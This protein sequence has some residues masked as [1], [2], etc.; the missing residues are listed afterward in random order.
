MPSDG[1][2]GR[3]Q[4]TQVLFTFLSANAIIGS[5]RP[6]A[7]IATA[8]TTAPLAARFG[9][10]SAIAREAIDALGAAWARRAR[11]RAG[12]AA[13]G[14]WAALFDG[15][16]SGV[17]RHA[18]LAQSYL[19]L[20]LA[21]VESVLRG[22]RADE[23]DP[24]LGSIGLDVPAAG[25]G[26]PIR[27]RIAAAAIDAVDEARAAGDRGADLVGELYAAVLAASFRR[28]LGEF[29]TPRWVVDLVLDEVG[30]RGAAALTRSVLDPC[31]G[32]GAFL[33]PAI[34][35]VRRRAEAARL[36]RAETL[37]RVVAHVR[38]GDVHPLA[39]LA[40]RVSYRLAI[41]DLVGAREAPP[42]VPIEAACAL[43]PGEG[44]DEVDLVVGNPP[45][46]R[47]GELPGRSRD[48]AAAAARRLGIVPRGRWGGTELDVSGV[49]ALAATERHLRDGGTLS[50]VVTAT[51]LRAPASAGLRRLR[52]PDGTPLRLRRVH[53]LTAA[54]PFPEV[55]AD[56]AVVTWERGRETRWPI[57]WERW[58]AAR[59]G[60]RRRSRRCAHPLPPDDRLCVLPPDRGELVA[61]LAG[62]S[63]AWRGRKGI[64]TDCNGVYFPRLLGPGETSGLTS[65]ETRPDAGRRPVPSFRASVETE[66]LFP[67]LKGAADVSAFATAPRDDVV[68]LVPN[69][70]I[71]RI[72]DE[73]TFAADHPR[74]FDYLRRADAARDGRGRPLLQARS[75]FRTRLAPTGA[76]FYAVANV[77]PY[78]FAAWKVVWAE[79]AAGLAAAVIGPRPLP[80]SVAGRRR[81]PVVCD[82]KLYFIALPG[83]PDDEQAAHFLCALLNAEPVRTF[84][85]GFA[86]RL[87]RGALT[88]QLRLPA[89][90]PRARRHRRLAELGRRA[91]DRGGADAR[92]AAAIDDATWALLREGEPS[93]LLYSPGSR[94]QAAA[95]RGTR[96]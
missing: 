68:A 15:E 43:E 83:G 84:V 5:G 33:V 4:E 69:R 44:G 9:P 56:V 20:V 42:V 27:E 63:P 96:G 86:A 54:R 87:Q 58:E 53:E 39:A 13:A 72:P 8:E 32:A 59:D 95:R 55:S 57:A 26:R 79:I 75:T 14:R 71:H 66:L 60:R 19:G 65:V 51:H 12:R 80:G 90:R 34:G 28:R 29:Y 73:E 61:A 10:P 62:P 21:S 17:D 37:A 94:G 24:G 82:H 25:L 6:V 93:E 74:A 18:F 7:I 85:D 11:T 36:T 48:R 40:A 41:A 77:G 76:P 46:V 52:L 89:F 47:F 88:E 1:H 45:W 2:R 31:C 81:R 92:T 78:A 91:H 16:P 23:L 3:T 64:T 30:F 50:F 70:T 49:I 67:L 22:G 38:G 35:R